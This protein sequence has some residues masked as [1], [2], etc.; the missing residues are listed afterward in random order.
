MHQ[1][2]GKSATA[3]TADVIPVQVRCATGKACSRSQP[4]TDK[5]ASATHRH[6][7]ARDGR[8]RACKLPC[9]AAESA[10]GACNHSGAHLWNLNDCERVA[11]PAWIF[12]QQV[13]APCVNSLARPLCQPA[14]YSVYQSWA[15]VNASIASDARHWILCQLC[16]S[17]FTCK[18]QSARFTSRYPMKAKT[19]CRADE[20]FCKKSRRELTCRRYR[21]KNELGQS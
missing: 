8:V 9:W 1:M 5:S 13:E 18:A 20:L 10:G 19:A 11:L 15:V 4:C 12:D 16:V 21:R 6:G 7:H 2:S 14:S 17:Q 3:E